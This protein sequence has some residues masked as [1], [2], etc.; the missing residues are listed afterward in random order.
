MTGLFSIS[1]NGMSSFP[2]PNSI[3]FQGGHIAPPT[4][5]SLDPG[6]VNCRQALERRNATIYT[7]RPGRCGSVPFFDVFFGQ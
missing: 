7:K 3:I 1:K 5:R 4:I 2:L 6:L